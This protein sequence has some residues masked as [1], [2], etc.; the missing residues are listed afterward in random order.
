MNT[1]SE[2]EQRYIFHKKM[3]IAGADEAGRGPLAGP[4]IAAAVVFPT[5]IE[6][7]GIDDSKILSE[8]KRSELEPLIKQKSLSWAIGEASVSEID[9]INILEASR[10]AVIRAVDKLSLKAD[11]ILLDGWPIPGW[12]TPHRGVVKGDRLCFSIAAASILAKCRRDNI[13]RELHEQFPC[14]G[15]AQN[16]GYPTPGHRQAL[17]QFGPCPYHRMS[18]NLLGQKKS[19]PPNPGFRRR[20]GMEAEE[21]ASN[22]LRNKGYNIIARNY[23][24]GKYELDIIASIGDSLVFVEVKASNSEIRPETKMTSAK[25]KNLARAADYYFAHNSDNWENV[26]FDLVAMRFSKG[27]WII[28]HCIDAFRPVKTY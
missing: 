27:L 16:K 5:E 23:R 19:P 25:I 22:F 8:L 10:L 3:T 12:K 9:N 26:R 17:Q 4:V 1:Y 2:L 14:Y 21:T 13:M 24:A 18:F 11:I 15:F 6:I 20:L 28:D 7:E